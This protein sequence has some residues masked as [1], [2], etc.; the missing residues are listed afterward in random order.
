MLF[1]SCN[2]KTEKINP[3]TENITES[4]YVSAVVKTE[5]QYQVFATVNG[6][7]NKIFVTEND[8]VKK[9]DPLIQ[10]TDESSTINRENAS[11]AANYAD[12]SANREKLADAKNS[13]TLAQSKS[14]NDSL[15]YQRQMNLRN[16]KIGTEN[17][18]EQCEAGKK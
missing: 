11:L 1:L 9:G 2:T 6:I 13:I 5:N 17:E 14:S 16:E 7:I 4:V 18:V 15:L 12:I 8:L 10:V 3:V